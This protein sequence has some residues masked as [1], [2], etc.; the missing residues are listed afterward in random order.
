VPFN[1]GFA[2]MFWF[3]DDKKQVR[4]GKIMNYEMKG[5]EPRRTKYEKAWRNVKWLHSKIDKY[6]FE[7]CFYGSHILTMVPD[8]EVHIVES[9]KTALIM[10]CVKPQH[11]WLATSSVTNLQE[12]FL[13][14]LK[15]RKVVLHPDK[16]ERSFGYWKLKSEEFKK[17]NLAKSIN[18]ST[19]VQ[20]TEFLGEGD[21]LADYV[22]KTTKYESIKK[23]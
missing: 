8:A 3:I 1:G 21:D 9:E 10:S 20:D 5:G 22:L 4:S 11:I 13:P 23:H 18:I 15:D 7:M 16:G 14:N 19:F 2:P 17:K 6:N 12:H